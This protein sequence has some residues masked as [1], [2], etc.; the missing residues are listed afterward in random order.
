MLFR[1]LIAVTHGFF[2]LELLSQRLLYPVFFRDSRPAKTPGALALSLRARGILLT[3][4]SGVCPVV[5]LLLLTLAPRPAGRDYVAFAL[6]VGGL[7]IALGLTVPRA[8]VLRADR[9][10][11]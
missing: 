7:G 10:I 8:L 6:S 5:S 1:S 11:E 3:V 4:S 9:I 2:I